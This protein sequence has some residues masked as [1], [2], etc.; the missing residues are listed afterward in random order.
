MLSSRVTLRTNLIDARDSERLGR[1]GGCYVLTI[2]LVANQEFL[3]RERLE[4]G[5]DGIDAWR[6]H[7]SKL[8]IALVHAQPLG[9]VLSEISIR[10]IRFPLLRLLVL[11]HGIMEALQTIVSRE[12]TLDRRVVLDLSFIDFGHVSTHIWDLSRGPKLWIFCHNGVIDL[13]ALI[14]DHAAPLL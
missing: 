1:L 5:E 10:K 4:L 12:D 9:D 11:L 3:A 14:T 8:C 6:G 13:E 2:Q 7:T